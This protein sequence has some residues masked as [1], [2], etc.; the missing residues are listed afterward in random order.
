MYQK[1]HYRHTSVSEGI[2]VLEPKTKPSLLE[3]QVDSEELGK[4]MKKSMQDEKLVPDTYYV[5]RGEGA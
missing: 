1:P 2:E 3:I 4:I 5:E